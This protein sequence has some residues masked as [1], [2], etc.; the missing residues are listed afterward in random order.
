MSTGI[1]LLREQ[2]FLYKMLHFLCY[3]YCVCMYVCA[4]CLTISAVC[5]LDNFIFSHSHLLSAHFSTVK[6][7]TSQ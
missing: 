5:V 2:Y 7:S 4:R 3:F 6:F 1:I